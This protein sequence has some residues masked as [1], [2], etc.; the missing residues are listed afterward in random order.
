MKGYTR[1]QSK[2]KWEIPIDIGRDP[3]TSNTGKS[4]S[5]SRSGAARQKAKEQWPF[6]SL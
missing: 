2:G 5:W 6:G 4:A 1:Q 3:A